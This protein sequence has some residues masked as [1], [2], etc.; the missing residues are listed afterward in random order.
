MRYV[1]NTPEKGILWNAPL[2]RG[3]GWHSKASHVSKGRSNSCSSHFSNNDNNLLQ[4]P[5]LFWSFSRLC[6]S[7][8]TQLNP[9]LSPLPVTMELSIVLS[10]ESFFHA[11]IAILMFPF[12]PNFVM[13]S[14]TE[15]SSKRIKSHFNN[16]KWDFKAWVFF[17]FVFFLEKCS[18]KRNLGAPRDPQGRG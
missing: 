2:W 15:P 13:D 1:K 4:K 9:V 6:S 8:G 17:F 7:V 12:D 14:S 10:I 18:I 11:G 5:P 3:F 16:N